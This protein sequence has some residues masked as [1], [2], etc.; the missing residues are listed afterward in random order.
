MRLSESSLSILLIS[1]SGARKISDTWQRKKNRRWVLR[2]LWVATLSS[3]HKS[4]V[5]KARAAISLGKKAAHLH[6][7]SSRFPPVR[8]NGFQKALL[9]SI[10]WEGLW[11]KSSSFQ[12]RLLVWSERDD[13][14]M[15]RALN[16]SKT[17][18]ICT[19]HLQMGVQP[20][21]L[22]LTPHENPTTVREKA[23]GGGSFAIKQQANLKHSSE[24]P[25]SP[26]FSK[27]GPS[28][29]ANLSKPPKEETIAARPSNKR[30]S[31][32][33]VGQKRCDFFHSHVTFR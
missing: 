10:F 8:F 12:Y 17:G 33:S 31:Q 30:K 4:A 7:Y 18:F 29:K 11:L 1:L 19:T 9:L 27:K 21:L 26:I 23:E 3:S 24:D 32:T 28:K 13:H 14:Y 22:I 2:Q 6:L 16:S 25:A 20:P 15:E 5:K